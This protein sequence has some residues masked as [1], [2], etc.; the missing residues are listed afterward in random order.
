M[1]DDEKESWEMTDAE[2][3]EFLKT[4]KKPKKQPAPA[5]AGTGFRNT[6]SD[7]M[8]K[9]HEASQTK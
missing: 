9:A 7:R 2:Y 1:A 3:K 6:L 4:G 8:K 5:P